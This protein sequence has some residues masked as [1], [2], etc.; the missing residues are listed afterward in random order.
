MPAGNIPVPSSSL[1]FNEKTAL[2]YFQ[3]L[4]TTTGLLRDYQNDSRI[5]L[6][7]DQAL[8]YYAL[9]DI[10]ATTQDASALSLANQIQRV[11]LSKL[12]RIISILESGLYTLRT[13]SVG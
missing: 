10:Y 4:N 7:D 11:N 3:S 2:A 12:R 9:T 1:A 5:F 6:A 8:D 13:L